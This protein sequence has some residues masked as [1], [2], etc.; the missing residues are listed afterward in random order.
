MLKVDLK[1]IKA[2]T[3]KIGYLSNFAINRAIM[4]TKGRMYSVMP[5]GELKPVVVNE[6]TQL[7]SQS[8]FAAKDDINKA[9][10]GNP[11]RVEEAFLDSESDTLAIFYSV[12]FLFDLTTA[13]IEICN[14]RHAES[15]V[16]SFVKTYSDAG[17]IDYLSRLYA[18]RIANGYAMWRNGKGFERST[19]VRAND[20]ESV[21]IF[22]F[23]K[24]KLENEEN[25]NKLSE[26]ISKGLKGQ[27][28]TLEVEMYSKLGK[29]SAVYP[30]Q[31]FVNSTSKFDPSR[32][33]FKDENNHALIH[34]QKI[35]NAIRTIDIWHPSFDD[36]G[37]IAVE[38]FG[39]NSRKAAAYRH[40]SG[41]FY[42]YLKEV[43]YAN[44]DSNAGMARVL[45]CKN[46]EEL[47]SILDAHYFMSV[48]LRGG[49]FGMESKKKEDKANKEKKA[50][51]ESDKEDK[52]GANE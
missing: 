49:V 19:I 43:V 33:Y 1:E 8:Q 14:M 44:D 38:P 34:S 6:S 2:N 41:D 47:D 48:L 45:F 37:A 12:D 9:S 16:K 17:G 22:N 30:S 3:D 11:Q 23:V 15:R 25:I 28:I 26:I 31:E 4:P 46:F 50:K 51:E 5:N 10:S 40:E 21:H 13:N 39:S 42:S 32:V 27:F 20:G 52:D 35:G 24:N 18:E 7:G 29:G 36:V